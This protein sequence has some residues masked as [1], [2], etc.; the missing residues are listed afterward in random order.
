MKKSTL[1]KAINHVIDMK[2][3]AVDKYFQ[4]VIDPLV[5][6][7]SNPEAVISKKYEDWTL[8]DQQ[9]LEQVY[10]TIPDILNDFRLEKEYKAISKLEQEA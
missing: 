8:V 1:D 7:I 6:E 4:E 2:M 9:L 5:K 3:K 10:Q